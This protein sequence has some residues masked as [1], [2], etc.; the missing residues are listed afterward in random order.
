MSTRSEPSDPKQEQRQHL[1]PRRCVHPHQLTPTFS[2]RGWCCDGRDFSGGCRGGFYDFNKTTVDDVT[3]RCTPCGF[4]LCEF[5]AADPTIGTVTAESAAS[6]LSYLRKERGDRGTANSQTRRL[7]FTRVKTSLRTD[8]GAL[9][10]YLHGGI[11]ETISRFKFANFR[12]ASHLLSQLV[13]RLNPQPLKRGPGLI[14]D[15]IYAVYLASQGVRFVHITNAGGPTTSEATCMDISDGSSFPVLK[16]WL[17]PVSNH[18]DQVIATAKLFALLR[19]DIEPID[20]PSLVSSADAT[21]PNALGELAPELARSHPEFSS[22]F[23]SSPAGLEFELEMVEDFVEKKPDVTRSMP[24]R[25]DWLGELRRAVMERLVVQLSNAES[26]DGDLVKSL[27]LL[28][29]QLTGEVRL[30]TLRLLNSAFATDVANAVRLL[31]SIASSDLANLIDFGALEWAENAAKHLASINSSIDVSEELD[32]LKHLLPPSSSDR[33]DERLLQRAGGVSLAQNLSPKKI[34]DINALCEYLLLRD[35]LTV[36]RIQTDPPAAR[37]GFAQMT[38][39]ISLDLGSTI[40]IEMEPVASFSQLGEAIRLTHPVTDLNFLEFCFELIGCEISEGLVIDFQLQSDLLL[41][42][43]SVKTSS[44]ETKKILLANRAISIVRRC[45]DPISHIPLRAKLCL[46]R[47]EN[48]WS[49]FSEILPLLRSPGELIVVDNENSIANSILPLAGLVHSPRGWLVPSSGLDAHILEIFD[50]YIPANSNNNNAPGTYPPVT[51]AEDRVWSVEI[52]VGDDIP[53][54]LVW[55]M[56]REEVVE[57]IRPFMHRCWPAGGISRLEESVFTSGVIA[58]GLSSEEAEGISSRVGGTVQTRVRQD[59]EAAINAETERRASPSGVAVPNVSLGQR[60]KSGIVVSV[61]SDSYDAVDPETG[62]LIERIIPPSRSTS[63][64]LR[65]SLRRR[66][67][68]ALVQ[69]RP[70]MGEDAALLQA[71]SFDREEADNDMEEDDDDD[72]NDDDN[73]EEESSPTQRGP[74]GNFFLSIGDFLTGMVGL[75]SDQP[76]G[77]SNIVARDIPGLVRGPTLNAPI[78]ERFSAD[79]L[80]TDDQR[81]LCENEKSA[82]S[83]VEV[84][85]RLWGDSEWISTNSELPIITLWKS[86]SLS[87]IEKRIEF[88]FVFHKHSAVPSG[89]SSS[90]PAKRQRTGWNSD[91]NEEGSEVGSPRRSVPNELQPYMHALSV[92]SSLPGL[93]ESPLFQLLKQNLGRKLS[94]QLDQVGLLVAEALIRDAGSDESILPEWI[95]VVPQK[96]AFLF[97]ETLRLRL[98]RAVSFP[99]ALTVHWIEQQRLGDLLNR[100][101]QLQSDLNTSDITGRRMQ[102]LSQELSNVEER[103]VRNSFWLGCVKSCLAKLRKSDEKEFIEMTTV[104]LKRIASSPSLLE[105]QF[106]GE[107]GFGSAVTRSFFSEVGKQFLKQS[108]AC[109]WLRGEGEFVHA[110]KRGLRLKPR[111]SVEAQ[112]VENCVLL[113]RLIGRAIAE[114]YIMPLP[115]SEETWAMIRDPSEDRPLSALPMPG[116]GCDGEFIGACARGDVQP[117]ALGDV[118]AVF[119]E[120]GFSGIEIVENGSQIAVTPSNFDEFIRRST[121]FYLHRGIDFQ[122]AAIRRGI[123]E[124]LPVESLLILTALELKTAVCGEDEICWSETSLRETLHFHENISSQLQDWLIEILLEL[125]NSQRA[126]FLDFV[127]SCP[128]MPP[129]GSLRI[130]VFSETIA[131]SNLTS[132]LLRPSMPPVLLESPSAMELGEASPSA[133]S[134]TSSPG[135]GTSF[136]DLGDVVGYPRSRA[137]V[138]HLYLPRYKAKQTLK[139]RLIEAMVSSVHHDEITG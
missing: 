130:D 127:T 87:V 22:L 115:I 25:K 128:R 44:G 120:T 65:D 41:G 3:F 37:S 30:L 47:L 135:R 1:T 118:G 138:S 57:V 119:V 46:A 36:A 126:T 21:I 116:D 56:I 11:L 88:R 10:Q 62:I 117:E 124:V 68:P 2:S 78:G 73:D 129:G 85:V 7:A 99:A 61:H 106:E 58:R 8:P 71:F 121:D 109:L 16:A 96:L 81:T 35:R 27:I 17:V 70:P 32:R 15:M 139:D 131:S 98:L 4:D 133:S 74:L 9:G 38:T 31:A 84:E 75:G 52:Q 113:G 112:V 50:S 83:K 100:R 40:N 59:R 110:G 13:H 64:S 77:K 89:G 49:E 72:D 5:C 137:C 33:L 29:P 14:P 60:V 95:Y 114:G 26:M 24:T 69:L 53:L 82:T 86:R 20:I 19:G 93:N 123:A 90:I 79:S 136:D 104:L 107:S 63:Q 42:F 45:A 101:T 125:T 67:V 66:I 6:D 51:I 122:L 23:P 134:Q 18:I 132:P 102:T 55:P 39:A 105:I 97:P 111:A 94:T 12:D 103:I 76:S 54:E 48:T 92:L 28:E 34:L 91:E 108:P 80:L 43:H